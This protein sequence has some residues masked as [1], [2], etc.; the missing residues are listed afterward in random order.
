VRHWVREYHV[1][2]L[3]FDAT[4]SIVD[5]S[6]EH[7][8]NELTRCARAD[9]HPRRL[10]VVAE[11][12]SQNVA[13]LNGSSPEAGVDSLWNEDWHHS[14]FVALMGQNDAYF[15]DYEGTAH[16]IA[17]M[18]RWNLLYQG[19]WYTWQKKGRGT[20]ARDLPSSSFVCFLENHD[21]VANTG[22]GFRLHQMTSPGQWRAAVSML[23]LGPGLP[24]LFQGQ[25]WAIAAPFV[26]FA[27]FDAPL[28]QAVCKGRLEFLSQFKALADPAVRETIPDPSDDAA[29]ERCKID[30]LQ[31]GVSEQAWQLHYD[32]LALRRSDA[33]LSKLG[34]PDVQLASS[35][36]SSTVVL[37]RYRV[38]TDERMVLINLGKRTRLRMNDPLLAPSFGRRWASS[39]C[40]EHVAYG[41]LGVADGLQRR[42]VLQAQCAWLLE[43]RANEA[44]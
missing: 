39:W 19:Q 37:L 38:N 28:A 14:A 31:D 41:G 42:W 34:T 22:P 27:D 12:E 30:W 23:L 20:D 21:Q 2:G 32:L 1:D 15:T 13:L 8:V 44:G 24:M 33:V 4:H 25:E 16:E 43:P 11:N 17:A 6:P 7:I 40:S 10:F 26:Y 3:R 36:P 5:R 29:F 9:A 35:A 18:A